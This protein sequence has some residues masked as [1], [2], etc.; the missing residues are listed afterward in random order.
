MK[1]QVGSHIVFWSQF[2][3]D[4][5]LTT[6]GTFLGALIGA[7]LGAYLAA[8]YALKISKKEIEY[9]KIENR[10]K[11]LGSFVR[12]N[13][14]FILYAGNLVKI[15]R[16]IEEV[17]VGSNVG[18]DKSNNFRYD[19]EILGEQIEI[20]KTING[21]DLIPPEIHLQ[22]LGCVEQLNLL[23]SAA[24]H[25]MISQ[26]LKEMKKITIEFKENVE[27]LEK[28]VKYLDRYAD[29]IEQELLSLK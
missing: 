26:D 17:I 18:Y 9:H 12:F 14:V 3:P 28:A 6:F 19:V 2:S 13:N 27:H 16:G 1:E 22:Y 7:G 21:W 24:S 11:E 25:F 23:H 10:R 5:W 8:K 29:E 15:C 20:L 4:A